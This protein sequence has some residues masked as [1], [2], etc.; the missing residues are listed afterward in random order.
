MAVDR[1]AAARGQMRMDDL[2]VFGSAVGDVPVES[3]CDPVGR[4]GDGRR[5]GHHRCL[6]GGADAALG[7]DRQTL[8]S[9]E[10]SGVVASDVEHPFVKAPAKPCSAANRIRQRPP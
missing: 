2:D 5:A 1:D 6:E 8:R 7:G 9:Q 3:V 10:E 4:A